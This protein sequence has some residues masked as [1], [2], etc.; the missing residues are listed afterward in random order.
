MVDTNAP[1]KGLLGGGHRTLTKDQHSGI[2]YEPAEYLQGPSARFCKG[3]YLRIAAVGVDRREWPQTALVVK[4]Q[5]PLWAV[6]GL[7]A[8][9]DCPELTLEA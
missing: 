2:H 9:N 7:R 6:S 8:Y 1:P 3:R 5:L 4:A